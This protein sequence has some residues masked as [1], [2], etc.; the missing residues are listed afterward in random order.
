MYTGISNLER[1]GVEFGIWGG[2]WCSILCVG[3]GL[4]VS[5]GV[6]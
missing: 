3:V 5:E 2:L 6:G 4:R 1:E